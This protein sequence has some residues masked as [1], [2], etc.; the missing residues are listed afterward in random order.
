VLVASAVLA[1][2]S[3]RLVELPALRLRAR[4]HQREHR[5]PLAPD[6]APAAAGAPAP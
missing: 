1:E 3:W 4:R 2:V 6:A 5:L